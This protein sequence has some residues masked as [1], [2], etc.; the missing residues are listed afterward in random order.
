MLSSRS[1]RSDIASANNSS[2]IP[3]QPHDDQVNETIQNYNITDIKDLH[4][5]LLTYLIQH[6]QIKHPEKARVTSML[7]RFKTYHE[8]TMVP[9]HYLFLENDKHLNVVLSYY[10]FMCLRVI[11]PLIHDLNRRDFDTFMIRLTYYY[12]LSTTILK[13]NKFILNKLYELFSLSDTNS[14]PSK[15]DDASASI[16]NFVNKICNTAVSDI[17]VNFEMYLIWCKQFSI[18]PYRWDDQLVGKLNRDD[19]GND[20]EKTVLKMIQNIGNPN[21]QMKFINTIN[22]LDTFPSVNEFLHLHVNKIFHLPTYAMEIKSLKEYVQPPPE[23]MIRSFNNCYIIWKSLGIQLQCTPDSD[24]SMKKLH[25]ELFNKNIVSIAIPTQKTWK[26]WNELLTLGVIVLDTDNYQHIDNICNS[27]WEKWFGVWRYYTDQRLQQEIQS[28]DTLSQVVAKLPHRSEWRQQLVDHFTHYQHEFKKQVN[29]AIFEEYQKTYTSWFVGEM[30]S[31]QLWMSWYSYFGNA[32][33]DSIENIVSNVPISQDVNGVI[34]NLFR[35]RYPDKVVSSFYDVKKYVDLDY[36]TDIHPF[37]SV[38][39]E[40]LSFPWQFWKRAAKHGR[41]VLTSGTFACIDILN[42]MFDKPH[43]QYPQTIR[44]EWFC[45]YVINGAL[46]ITF[47]KCSLPIT[48]NRLGWKG[49]DQ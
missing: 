35:I 48:K 4:D 44:K 22:V 36:Q 23:S 30:P 15:P 14:H 41:D 10:Q 1:P 34:N 13:I 32:D 26:Y 33:I 7:E 6:D 47:A 11:Q 21:L 46:A 18:H 2:V 8:T 45:D 43:Y 38:I 28:N 40:F 31:Q 29:P 12:N 3:P 39:Y 17:S 20:D 24:D 16:S 27:Q 42:A 5:R 9:L 25:I 49:L 19:L 37:K